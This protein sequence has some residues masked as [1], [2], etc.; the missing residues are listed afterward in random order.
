MQCS[1]LL[2]ALLSVGCASGCLVAQNKNIVNFDDVIVKGG[3]QDFPNNQFVSKGVVFD[4]PIPLQDVQFLQPDFFENVF[5]PNGGSP[6][7]ALWLNTATI[8]QINAD[9]VIP[10]TDTPAVTNLI[11]VRVFDGNV[12]TSL[13]TLRAFDVD[14]QLIDAVSNSTPPSQFDVYEIKAPGIARIELSQDSDG[15]LFDN[16]T[17]STPI[18]GIL[19]DVNCD[20]EVN[21][22]DVA[23]FIDT[24]TT[25][26]FNP[27]ADINQDGV[28]D[29]LDVAPF[30]ELLSGG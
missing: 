18:A 21:L 3:G 11:Q 19:G 6:P 22:L 29:L 10:G 27:K 7:N 26:P 1:T 8:F 13:G 24:L 9:F 25:D 12:G 2:I 4:Q 23:P 16:L 15:G 5:L 17:F 20:G 14:G 28:V 30:V